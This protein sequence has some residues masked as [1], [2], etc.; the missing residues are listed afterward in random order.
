MTRITSSHITILLAAA[1]LP[2]AASATTPVLKA[3][4]GFEG[5]WYQVY[6]AKGITWDDANAA[7]IAATHN[8]VQG[9]L[10][11][12]TAAAEDM[13]VDALRRDAM[14]EKPEAWVGGRQKDGSNEP[15]EGWMWINNE[16]PIS[17]AQAPLPSYSNWLDHEPNNQNVEKYLGVG[18]GNRFGWNDEQALGNIGGFVVE[19]DNA[20]PVDPSACTSP[21]GCGT[22]AGQ[23]LSFILEALQDDPKIGIRTYEFMD[24]PARCGKEPL[25]LF[26]DDGIPDNEVTIP[27]YLCG[28]PRF[29]L[30]E[31]ESEGIDISDGTVAIEN[32]VEDALPGNLYDC[33]G[34]FGALNGLDLDPQHRDKVTYQT[35]NPARMLENTVGDYYDPLSY[36]GSL[37]EVTFGCGSSRGKT[38]SLSYLGIGLSINF[39]AEF[40]LATNPDGNLDAFARLTRYKLEVLKAAVLES[41]VA[42][43]GT[44]WQKLGYRALTGLTGA[45]IKFHDRGNY[46]KALLMVRLF[47]FTVNNLSY[48][49]IVDEN[50]SGE[51]QVRSSNIEF[52]Y[53]DSILPFTE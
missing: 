51:H 24:D 28:S 20:V 25:E 2:L 26:F 29:L 21:E 4:G 48:D 46:E 10:A 37:S 44:F 22:T 39:G 49:S 30:V 14:L 34:P 3:E 50:Y 53:T 31:V 6:E 1:L 18:L 40:D 11:T 47:G 27:P 36:K 23:T 16:G 19:F 38:Y 15:G 52:M 32:K 41:K 8:A 35:T 9:H 42:L 13:Y 43:N 17:T 5:R 45:A 7:A 33:T 12:I